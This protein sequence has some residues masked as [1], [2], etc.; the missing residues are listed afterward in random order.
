VSQNIK[1]L[2]IRYSGATIARDIPLN[3]LIFRVFWRK[4]MS[5][6]QASFLLLFCLLLSLSTASARDRKT[7]PPAPLPEQLI[8]AKKVFLANGGG[9][10]LAYD[11]FYSGMQKWGKYEIVGSPEA[12]D[13]VIELGYKV[14]NGGTRVW[15][16]TNSYTGATQVGSVQIQDPQI[17]MTIFDTKTRLSL[18]SITDHTRLAR[19]EKNR[20]KEI[21]NSAERIVETLKERLTSPQGQPRPKL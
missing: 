4:H 10:D 19:L 12:A 17:V 13:I 18:W 6:I 20:E 8:N 1:G 9:S 16:A 2:C 14:V 5:R 15:S 3:P 21:I 7:I 11:A